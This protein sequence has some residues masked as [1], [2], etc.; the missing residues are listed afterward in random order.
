VRVTRSANGAFWCSNAADI[1]DIATLIAI[2][3]RCTVT[4]T[5]SHET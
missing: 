5:L 1:T 4:G 2:T 3:R